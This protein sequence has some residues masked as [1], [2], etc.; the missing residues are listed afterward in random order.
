ML[1]LRILILA[2]VVLLPAPLRACIVTD[3]LAV[4]LPLPSASPA[5][6][7]LRI[8]YPDLLISTDGTR[9]TLEG[10]AAWQPVGSGGERPPEAIL[11][12]ATV[13]DQFRY[14]YPLDYAS[15]ADRPPW[16]DPGRPRNAAL[17]EAL[18]FSDEAAARAS[19]VTVAQP[20]LADVSYR[21]TRKRGVSCQLQAALDHLAMADPAAAR[22]FRTPGG[23]FNWRRIAGTERLSTHSFGIAVDLNAELGGYW[24]WS[25]ARAGAVP[26]H[27]SQIPETVVHAMER[28]GFIWGGKWHHFDGMHFEYRP[29]LILHARMLATR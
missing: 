24:R 23:A 8:A 6:D 2:A 18:W 28:F 15:H 25:G 12:D 13:A 20:A 21:V 19:L 1:H 27:E 9:W 14:A 22:V 4:D 3:F 5:A 7:A 29:E 11:R 10:R 16:D 26:P 17:F